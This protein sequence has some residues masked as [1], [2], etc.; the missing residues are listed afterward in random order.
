[1]EQPLCIDDFCDAARDVIERA[2]LERPGFHRRLATDVE[3]DEPDP[4]GVADA[5][6]L[7][8]TLNAMPADRTVREGFVKALQQLQDPADC[9]WHEATHHPYHTTAHCVA[10]LELFDARPLYPL[11]GLDV[12]R[13]ESGIVE[14]LESLD[15]C[16]EP[17]NQSHRGAGVFAALLLVDEA[18][19]PWRDTYFDWLAEQTDPDTGLLRKGCLPGHVESPRPL[20]EHMAGTF[21]YVFNMEADR[22]PI[23][24]PD[25]LIDS[26]LSMIVHEPSDKYWFVG[27][28]MMDWVFCLTRARRQCGHRFGEVTDALRMNAAKY[29]DGL[30]GLDHESHGPFNDLHGLFGSFCAL[31]EF[32]IALPGEIV[33]E[34]PLRNVLDRRPFI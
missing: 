20:H 21:R 19:R 24:Y 12:Y 15:W 16:G 17:W 13:T 14:L 27:F 25:K 4:Y 9:L 7:Y 26:C 11:R 29:V 33:T 1:M 34:R 3:P 5:A 23:P 6:N 2:A 10:A 32:Q 30:R 28:L 8:Y 31:A 18:P 22:R